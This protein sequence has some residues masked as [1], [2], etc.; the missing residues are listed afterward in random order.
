MS[1]FTRLRSS[2]RFFCKIAEF[3]VFVF[4]VINIC[5][6]RLP[7]APTSIG[8]FSGFLP[9]LR[10]SMVSVVLEVREHQ[11]TVTCCPRLTVLWR[12]CDQQRDSSVQWIVYSDMYYV[13][14]HVELALLS[15]LRHN[16]NAITLNYYKDCQFNQLLI[17]QWQW[18]QYCIKITFS[19]RHIVIK[20]RVCLSRPVTCYLFTFMFLVTFIITDHDSVHISHV[21][22]KLTLW[23]QCTTRNHKAE[24]YSATAMDT[25]APKI[26]GCYLPER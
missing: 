21:S 26:L 22:I 16:I 5:A 6:P 10:V 3:L 1:Q 25:E 14:V 7:V 18:L 13:A 23:L 24:I 17:F 4:T 19:N 20:F 8:S 2:Q 12:G 15:T 9:D 11:W